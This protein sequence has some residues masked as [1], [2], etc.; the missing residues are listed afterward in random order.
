MTNTKKNLIVKEKVQPTTSFIKKSFKKNI[1]A[2]SFVLP[3]LVLLTIFLFI[4]FILSVSY[5]FTNYNILKPNDMQFVGLN[6]F[7]RL[8]SDSVF[9]TSLINTFKFA[10]IVVPLQL[11]M[12]LGLALLVNKKIKGIGFFR[13]AFFSPTVL[14]LVVIS[15]LWT[16]IYN[17]NGGLLN[18][19]IGL[20]GIT[21]QPFLTSTSQ[22]MPCIIFLS[23]WQGAGFQMMIFL[24][25]LQDIPEYLYEAADIDGAN[26]LHKFLFITIPGLKNISIFLCLTITI[27]A[28]QLLIQPMMMTQ[29]GP[30]NSTL[31]VVYEI[32]QYGYK[33]RSMG[34]GS[35]MAV[36]FTLMVLTIA[37]I[38]KKFVSDED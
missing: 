18:S 16:F 38:Q 28:F 26:K 21:P 3:A 27:S 22:A 8:L 37:L 4:P 9:K 23:A 7:K 17:P 2:I 24:A 15:I 13:L 14:S 29:G 11:A 10:V 30:Q 33:F 1:V 35:A 32:Y 25:G 20:F 31:T 6:N 34:Y 5:S 12:A 19:M 36:V